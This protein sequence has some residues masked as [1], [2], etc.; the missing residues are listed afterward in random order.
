MTRHK[1][2]IEDK[3][4]TEKDTLS[5]GVIEKDIRNGFGIKFVGRIGTQPRKT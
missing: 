3:V 5:E 1:D 4:K 2:F